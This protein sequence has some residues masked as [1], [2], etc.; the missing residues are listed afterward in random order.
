MTLHNIKAAALY[1]PIKASL[2][3]WSAGA[4]DMTDNSIESA[5]SQWPIPA[6]AFSPDAWLAYRAIG[7][8]MRL[9]IGHDR[10]GDFCRLVEGIRLER[11][12]VNIPGAVAKE[13]I[14]SGL[15]RQMEEHNNR[16]HGGWRNSGV[17][18]DGC[19]VYALEL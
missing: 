14:N 6:H 15:L 18:G 13:L 9:L 17:K 16:T 19:R 2:S 5:L 7:S 11:P 10:H 8:G 4:A 12:P 1:T 3:E